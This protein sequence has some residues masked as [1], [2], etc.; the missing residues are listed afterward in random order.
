MHRVG[1]VEARELDLPRPGR[2][3]QVLD[4]PVVERPVVLE[5]ERA[6]RVRDALDRVRLRRAR[7][8]TSG[9]CTRRRRSGGGVA[10]RMRYSTGSR[11]LMLGE[12]MSIFARSTWAPSANSPARIRAEEVEVLLH[13]PVAVRAVPAGLGQ[14]AAVLAD[15]VR[16]SGRRRRPGRSGSAARPTR[17]AARSSRRRSRGASPQSKPEPAHV[18][19]DR[20]R[21]TPAPPWRGWC[22]RSGGGSGR[23]TPA[24]RP[25]LRQIDLACPMCR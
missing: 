7:S 17:R 21:R 24:A 13:R 18:R 2:H 20:R 23:R 19:L 12:A 5:L 3:R 10:W 14:R 22:R 4:E 6:E 1:Q 9:R 25:K 11:M 16:A 8:R 15:L